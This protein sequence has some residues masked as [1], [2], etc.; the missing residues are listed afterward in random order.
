M[1]HAQFRGGGSPR[2]RLNEAFAAS[3]LGVGDP[4]PAIRCFDG[5]GEPFNLG[6]LRGHYSVVIFGC[7]T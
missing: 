3:G 5:K 7:L 4:L 2:N 6:N 1:A